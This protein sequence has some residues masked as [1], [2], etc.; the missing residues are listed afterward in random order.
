MNGGADSDTAIVLEPEMYGV[1]LS[2]YLPTNSQSGLL[3]KLGMGRYS[4]NLSIRVK[5]EDWI[6][7]WSNTYDENWGVNLGLGYGLEMSDSDI[8]GLNL[9]LLEYTCHLVD[10]IPDGTP[11][12]CRSDPLLHI[13]GDLKITF[14]TCF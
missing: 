8:A 11:D 3:V 1:G 2:Y 14:G 12:G 9:F 7:E 13:M 10:L 5:H 6:N 4:G